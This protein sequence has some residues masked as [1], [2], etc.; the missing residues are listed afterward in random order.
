[1]HEGIQYIQ[2]LRA[3]ERFNDDEIRFNLASEINSTINKINSKP[4]SRA[5]DKD[6]QSL[7]ILEVA[8][9]Y[10]ELTDP[11]DKQQMDALNKAMDGKNSRGKN[12]RS[13]Q[14]KL[15]KADAISNAK[16]R[17]DRDL[18]LIARKRDYV[19]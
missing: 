3:M 15:Q 13:V 9:V 12:L 2:T 4:I 14:F 17:I 18:S 10:I 11:S 6:L 19:V 7:H 16:P 1:M 8:S 5:S